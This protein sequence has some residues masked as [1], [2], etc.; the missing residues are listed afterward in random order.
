MHIRQVFVFGASDLE[1]TQAQPDQGPDPTQGPD[2]MGSGVLKAQDSTG[3]A[4]LARQTAVSRPVSALRKC[5]GDY[6]D[7]S[8]PLYFLA[9]H[10]SASGEPPCSA[11]H[12]RSCR[13]WLL[14]L[15]HCQHQI[16]TGAGIG[17]GGGDGG[18]GGAA[19]AQVVGMGG[20]KWTKMAET[21]HIPHK[22]V[23]ADRRRS[24][25]MQN[26]RI[27]VRANRVPV[28]L[29]TGSVVTQDLYVEAK[30]HVALDG[31]QVW[32][33]YSGKVTTDVKF[34]LTSPSGTVVEV[35]RYTLDDAS[36]YRTHTPLHPSLGISLVKNL[37]VAQ[38]VHSLEGEEITGKWLVWRL[39]PLLWSRHDDAHSGF[40]DFSSHC[41]TPLLTL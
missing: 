15:R 16:G 20:G 7:G 35:Q 3:S 25:S 9:H 27:L 11:G 32:A 18:E 39:D 36:S 17:G 5:Y 37:E 19:S 38:M 34:T 41:A 29:A 2:R 28:E 31:L 26:K 30:G 22:L 21:H 12:V 33:E 24:A 8:L 4:A 40:C 13:D 6:C 10:S 14:L 1:L 23:F